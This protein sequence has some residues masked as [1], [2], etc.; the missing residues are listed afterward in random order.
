MS[1]IVTFIGINIQLLKINV[2]VLLFL[3]FND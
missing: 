1:L 3:R 2:P